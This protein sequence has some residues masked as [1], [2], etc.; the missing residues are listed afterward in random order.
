MNMAFFSDIADSF[1]RHKLYTAYPKRQSDVN[2]LDN[3]LKAG[4]DGVSVY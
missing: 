1:N 4:V 2:F 3:L